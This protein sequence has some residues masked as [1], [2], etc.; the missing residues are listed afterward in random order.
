MA[1]ASGSGS[2]NTRSSHQ[3]IVKCNHDIPTKLRTVKSGGHVGRKFYGC[4][5]W[6]AADCGFFKWEVN[7][8]YS[9]EC[10]ECEELHVKLLEQFTSIAELELQFKIF[11]DKVSKIKM[12]KD[13][14]AAEVEEMRKE[15][16]RINA[17]LAKSN[18]GE[19]LAI[20]AL[21][22]SWIFF[23]VIIVFMK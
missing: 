19:K 14:M 5:M 4:A 17:E 21:L 7:E 18:G 8:G 6:P 23:A 2:V 20:R 22:L 11:E 16:A 3:A 1:S 13:K 10:H 15:M 12:K 9:K